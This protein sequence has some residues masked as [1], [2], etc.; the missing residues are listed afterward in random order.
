M[1]DDPI[2]YA[3]LKSFKAHL[4][5]E[6]AGDLYD[7]DGV[8]TRAAFCPTA[9]E[10]MLTYTDK[11]G[12]DRIFGP[13]A[14]A[15]GRMQEDTLNLAKHLSVP[16][17]YIEIAENDY[18]E[19]ESWRH[20]IYASLDGSQAIGENPIMMVGGEH[21]MTRRFIIRMTTYFLESDQDNTEVSRLGNAA[22]SF[23]ESMVTASWE[24]P[25][26]WAWSVA[27]DEGDRITDP[28]GETP[29][30]VYPVIGH[31]RRRGGV[32][33]DLIFDSKIYV[34]VSTFKSAIA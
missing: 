32:P 25:N 8:L 17:A 3:L 7:Y 27:D 9:L 11:D 16:S 30:R 6:W 34:E 21:A 24:M 12:V 18:E 4:D 23:L 31:T 1:T 2:V 20:S 10:A 28:F 14:T 15:V 29:W 5:A 26:S 13:S 19:V 22:E 33:D